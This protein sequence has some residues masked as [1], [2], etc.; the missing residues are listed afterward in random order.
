MFQKRQMV[1]VGQIIRYRYLWAKEATS[2]HD[3]VHDRP[4]IVVNVVDKGDHTDVAVVPLTHE[5]QHDSRFMAVPQAL[6]EQ[7]GLDGLDQYVVVSELNTF[8][9]PTLD[10]IP[11]KTRNVTPGFFAGV[12]NALD[13]MSRLEKLAVVSREHIKQRDIED[14]RQRRSSR[15]RER[16]RER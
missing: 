11:S 7:F 16:D 9:A 3:V 1:N 6:R 15:A 10:I 12:Q 8:S 5:P 14:Y 2:G 13:E 4:C